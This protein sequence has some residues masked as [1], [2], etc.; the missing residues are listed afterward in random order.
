VNLAAKSNSDLTPLRLLLADDD[1]DD[2]MFFRKALYDLPMPLVLA[3]VHDGEKLLEYLNHHINDLPDVL[4]LDLNMPRKNGAECL[5]DIKA[6]ESFSKIP[7][8]ICSTSLH[9]SGADELYNHGA[10]YYIRKVNLGELKKNIFVL[11]TKL[12]EEKFVRP[13]RGKFI[14]GF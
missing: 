8:I 13:S 2:C 11:L 12:I 6:N 1:K 10:H 3:T 7:V 5:I 14:L 9:E 4:V